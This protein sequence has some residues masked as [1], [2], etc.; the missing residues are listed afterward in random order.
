MGMA[1][2]LQIEP[3]KKLILLILLLA[4]ITEVVPLWVAERKFNILDWIANVYGIVLGV[5]IIKIAQRSKNRRMY[6]RRCR[7]RLNS[8]KA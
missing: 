4:T 7:N 2:S 8:V 3:F 1:K 6:Y 5:L